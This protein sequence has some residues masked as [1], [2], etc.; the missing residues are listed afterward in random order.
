MCLMYQDC[1]L[2]QRGSSPQRGE[3]VTAKLHFFNLGGGC[4]DGHISLPFFQTM[5]DLGLGGTHGQPESK[6]HP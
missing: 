5:N 2:C 3:F 1:C 4:P 6:A